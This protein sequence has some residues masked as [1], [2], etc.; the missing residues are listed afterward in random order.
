MSLE[1]TDRLIQ[2]PRGIIENV[3]IKVDKFVLPIDF[4]ILDMPEDSRVPIILGRPFL[5]TARAMI[6][7]AED[8]ECYRI[9]DLDDAINVEAQELLA[10]DTSDLFLLKGLEKLID[11]SVL[12]SYESF[13]CKAFD[14][15]DSGE[16]IQRIEYVNAP[17]LV[18][19]KIV[20]PNKVKKSNIKGISLSYYIHK[21]LMEDDY[22]PVIQLQRR[23][24]PKVQDVVKNNIVKLLDSGLIYPILDSS[25][26]SPIHVV[27]KKGGM[28]VVLNDDNE[29]IPSRIITGWI[30]PNPDRTRRLRK[31]NIHLSIWDFC[32]PTNVVW[33]MQRTSY[34]PKMH[35]AAAKNHFI[36]LNELMELRDGAY[37]NTRIYKERTKRWHDSRLCGDKDFKVGD[38]VFLF[39]S[40]FKMHPGKLKPRWYGPNVVMTVYPYGTVEIIDRNEIIFKVKRQRLKKYHDG[41]IEAEDKEVVEFKEDTT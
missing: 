19:Q 31:N 29:L 41:L 23:L 39:N 24:N 38:K 20:E 37:K 36:E 30:L 11:Q 35:D 27:P 32:L 17:Y 4:V 26:V 5:A 8:D 13:E 22:K 28:T 33:I 14:D 12:E 10:N 6:D 9:D 15:S 34:F 18:A 40:R 7:P 21:I 2:Y 16:P 1:L 25:W 3:L